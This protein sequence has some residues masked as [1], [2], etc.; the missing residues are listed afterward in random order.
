M[1]KEL[2]QF[3]TP[4]WAA[5]E[6]V[7]LADLQ[8]SDRVVEPSCG[9]GSLLRVIPGSIEAVGVEIDPVMAEKA[10]ETGR[11]I[12]VG[13]FCKVS[14]PFQPT[15]VFGNP[16]FQ[17]SVVTRFIKKCRQILPAGGRVLF[18]LSTHILQTPSTVMELLEGFGVEHWIAP[19]TVFPRLQRPLSVLRMVKGESFSRGLFLYEASYFISSP[20]NRC[21]RNKSWREIV[22]WA[23]LQQGGCASLSVIYTC[24]EPLRPSV[25]RWWRE[26][27]RQILQLHFVRLR[28]GVWATAEFSREECHAS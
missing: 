20:P 17:S 14:L 21:N 11:P 24:V 13:D 3:T 8:L 23:L 16:P 4:P 1:N 19:R 22:H 6:L 9:D 5:E 15:V 25:G 10:R 18:L 26:K 2:G 27:V 12:I 7:K 28:K